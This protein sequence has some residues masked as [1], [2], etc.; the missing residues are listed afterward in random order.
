M[1]LGVAILLASVVGGLVTVA[2]GSA[3]II[4]L[5]RVAKKTHAQASPSASPSHADCAGCDS[6]IW[7]R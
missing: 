2:V 1:P 5:R 7:L 4:Q 3:R 6:K